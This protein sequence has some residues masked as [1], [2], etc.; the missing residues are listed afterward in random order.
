M[1]GEVSVLFMEI[2]DPP[3]HSDT[4]DVRISYGDMEWLCLLY[5][6][7]L[8]SAGANTVAIKLESKGL[9]HLEWSRLGPGYCESTMPACVL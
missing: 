8:G 3:I 4:L 6:A 1:D 5:S 9:D 2:C 7:S